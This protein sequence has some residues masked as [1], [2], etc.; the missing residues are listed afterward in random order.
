MAWQPVVDHGIL[1]VKASRLHSETP[2]SVG[3]LWMDGQPDAKTTHNTLY[4]DIHTPDGIRTRNPSK[5][6]AE[7]CAAT[8]IGTTILSDIDVSN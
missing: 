2:Q 5:R 6:T 8:G 4:V 1:T 3:L 7:D